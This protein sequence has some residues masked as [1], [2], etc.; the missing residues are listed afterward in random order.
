MGP[1]SDSR[2]AGVRVVGFAESG[3][4]GCEFELWHCVEWL[5]MFQYLHRHFCSGAN[6]GRVDFWVQILVGVRIR[7]G[8]V[9]AWF[10]SHREC[11]G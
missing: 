7:V 6:K 9:G 8:K 2:P 3:C 11:D 1:G 4:G 5:L 10:G